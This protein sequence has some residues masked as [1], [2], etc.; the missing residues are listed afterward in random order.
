MCCTSEVGY[1]IPGIKEVADL[2]VGDTLTSGARPAALPQ[3]VDG[4]G[5]TR[6]GWLPTQFDADDSVD[7]ECRD[8]SR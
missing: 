2:R 5:H 6:H 7:G 8:E 1:I 3:Y 4:A